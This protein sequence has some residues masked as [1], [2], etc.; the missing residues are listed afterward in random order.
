MMREKNKG[1]TLVELLVVIA[2]I[3]M[4]MSVMMP[5]LGKVKK[6]ATSTS[7]KANL[8]A[9]AIGFRMYLD[10]NRDVMPP[11]C[12]MPSINSDGTPGIAEFIVPY[13]SDAESLRCKGDVGGKRFESE[14]TSYEYN[15]MLAGKRVSTSFLVK[16]FGETNV[17]VMR[18]FEAFHGEAGKSG[19]TNYLYADG[20]VGDFASN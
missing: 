9:Q 2:I 8:H 7:C 5:A 16:K 20:R 6:M 12:Q 10:D 13:L 18:D 1:F 11:A 3:S 17:H 4:L 19:G 15:S 14:G